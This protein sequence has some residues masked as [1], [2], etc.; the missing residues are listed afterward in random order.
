MDDTDFID[1]G[2]FKT[3]VEIERMAERFFLTIVGIP[4]KAVKLSREDLGEV[5]RV[6]LA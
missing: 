6:V 3:G 1:G 4:R 5:V 2:D